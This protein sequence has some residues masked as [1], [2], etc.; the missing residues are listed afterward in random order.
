MYPKANKNKEL[1]RF[2]ELGMCIISTNKLFSSY[3]K[4]KQ[5]T[6]LHWAFT[7]VHGAKRCNNFDEAVGLALRM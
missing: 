5:Y 7:L 4:M 3:S 2:D 6:D 1:F